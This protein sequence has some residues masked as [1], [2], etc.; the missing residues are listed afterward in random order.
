MSSAAYKLIY[1]DVVGAPSRPDG[2]RLADLAIPSSLRQALADDYGSEARLSP[3]QLWAIENGILTARASFL[4]SAPTNSGK[5]LIAVLRMFASAIE[6]RSR[7]VFV[8]PLKAL[9]EE[10][11]EEC[12]SGFHRPGAPGQ[13]AA[14]ESFVGWLALSA[15]VLHGFQSGANG[16]APNPTVDW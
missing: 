8:V 12:A 15:Y 2:P 14:G 10:K 1:E 4:I 5:T 11:A 7:H 16:T 3:P 9:A 6:K 13:F